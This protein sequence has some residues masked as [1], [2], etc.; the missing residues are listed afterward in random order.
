MVDGQDALKQIQT[1]WQSQKQWV[2]VL[3]ITQSNTSNIA[4]LQ[5]PLLPGNEAGMQPSNTAAR[6]QVW[7]LFLSAVTRL[8]AAAT[9]RVHLSV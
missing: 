8:S 2:F 3:D 6:K 4:S 7:L 9:T 1:Q 5:L